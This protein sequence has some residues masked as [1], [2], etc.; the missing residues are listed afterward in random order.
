MK[1]NM[2]HVIVLSADKAMKND[3]ITIKLLNRL[4]SWV[5]N[6][7]T[8][9]DLNTAAAGFSTTTFGFKY[10]M[11]GIYESYKKL[12]NGAQPVYFAIKLQLNN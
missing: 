2:T 3:E 10:I 11:N 6:S 8:D 4:P 9:N 12:A 7:S 5:E 1:G